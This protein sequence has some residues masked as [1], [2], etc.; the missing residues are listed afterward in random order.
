MN[1]FIH[2]AIRQHDDVE[3]LKRYLLIIFIFPFFCIDNTSGQDWI[4]LN[5]P[6]GYTIHDFIVTNK[7][8]ELFVLSSSGEIFS[9][10]DKGKNWKNVSDGIIYVNEF[11]NTKSKFHETFAGKLFLLY[12]LHF[13]EYDYTNSTWVIQNDSIPLTDYTSGPTGIIYAG[14]EK[15]FFRSEDDGATFI[16]KYDWIAPDL[17]FECHGYSNNF[18][19]LETRSPILTFDDDGVIKDTINLPSEL[20]GKILFDSVSGNLM[21]FNSLGLY[22]TKDR[23]RKWQ[24]ID[25]LRIPGGANNTIFKMPNGI[26][27]NISSPIRFSEDGGDTWKRD[28]IYRSIMNSF[29]YIFLG[30]QNDYTLFYYYEGFNILEPGQNSNRVALP[31]LNP[32]VNELLTYGDNRIICNT[33]HNEILHLSKDNGLTWKLVNTPFSFWYFRDRLLD[34]SGNFYTLES[35]SVIIFNFETE[36]VTV[37]NYPFDWHNYQGGFVSKTD[38]AF[39]YDGKS[40]YVTEDKANSW[41][42]HPVNR[43]LYYFRDMKCS[44]NDI[45]YF[46]NEDSI[47]Y[48]FDFGSNWSFFITNS[49][50]LDIYQISKN[51]IFYWLEDGIPSYKVLSSTDFGKTQVEE[52]GVAGTWAYHIDE[53][54][55]QYYLS[56]NP[57]QLITTIHNG[58]KEYISD[59]GLDRKTQESGHYHV[60]RNGYIYYYSGHKLPYRTTNKLSAIKSE[61]KTPLELLVY[62]NPFNEETQLILPDEFKGQMKRCTVY[63]GS[64]SK[65]MEFNNRDQ[66]INFKGTQLPNGLYFVHVFTDN[67]MRASGKMVLCK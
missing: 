42:T 61:K 15:S 39:L 59:K 30:I 5:G 46:Y 49:R 7:T 8:N 9:S 65:L 40:I 2:L 26:I 38:K 64:G 20:C 35:D 62:P 33:D 36:E 19:N 44:L 67:N 16:K 21:N 32:L 28:T 22:K 11:F 48:S 14:N 27:F 41:S 56:N 66:D 51:N 54:D 6:M 43:N 10:V 53:N 58:L 60:S 55:V 12:A 31:V 17:Q 47:F 18:V 63:D 1:P 3:L 29:N 34:A 50:V 13:Y 24:K 25:S 45:L 57:D 52:T 37:R 4:P 23:G